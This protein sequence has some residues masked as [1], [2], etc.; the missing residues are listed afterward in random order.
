MESTMNRHTITLPG[1]EQLSR[2]LLKIC[3]SG[4]AVNT[5]V[6]WFTHAELH[7]IF[8]PTGKICK[9]HPL[10]YTLAKGTAGGE[11]KY[12]LR[13][14][15]A[16]WH[17]DIRTPEQIKEQKER[18]DRLRRLEEARVRAETQQAR[19]QRLIEEAANHSAP[20]MF[21]AVMQGAETAP[22]DES[23]FHL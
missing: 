4:E 18:D 8:S 9:A 3:A 13:D 23:E 6:V 20:G 15:L 11:R 12:D 17:I 10:E 19:K 22:A 14:R 1:L 21:L 2:A 7:R 16:S 5:L